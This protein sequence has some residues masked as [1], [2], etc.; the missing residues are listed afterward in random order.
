MTEHG[1]GKERKINGELAMP[2]LV[3]GERAAEAKPS[4]N[5]RLFKL[6]FI[7]ATSSSTLTP[8]IYVVRV[9]SNPTSYK[10]I[11]TFNWTHIRNNCSAGDNRGGGA[12]REQQ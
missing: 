12:T 8:D 1:W 9:V 2:I 4:A 7:H 3:A 10:H 6:Y 11:L 5:G